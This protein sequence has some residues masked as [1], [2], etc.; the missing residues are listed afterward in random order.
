MAQQWLSIVEY[1]RA[2]SVSDMTVRRRIKTGKLQS[3]LKEGKYYIPVEVGMD[4]GFIK[5]MS[6][7]VTIVQ[8]DRK[9]VPPVIEND[10]FEM[11]HSRPQVQAKTIATHI[12]PKKTHAPDV[13]KIDNSIV[14]VCQQMLNK[15][16]NTEHLMNSKYQAQLQALVSDSKRKD[17]EITQLKQQIE[18]LQ[19]LVKILE[20]NS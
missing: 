20:S 10:A 7:K 19:V 13:P 15:L 8:Q 16:S 11:V 14:D 2:F 12:E 1:A 18:D 9:P 17:S 3:V 4:G 5:P 6:P